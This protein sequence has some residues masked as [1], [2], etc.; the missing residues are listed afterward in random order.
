M[1]TKIGKEVVYNNKISK[2]SYIQ[3]MYQK[4]VR[5]FIYTKSIPW[6]HRWELQG[7]YTVFTVVMEIYHFVERIWRILVTPIFLYGIYDH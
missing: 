7:N 5:L 3:Y 2:Q 1:D 4:I 6:H